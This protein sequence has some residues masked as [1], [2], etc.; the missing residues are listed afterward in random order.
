LQAR[1]NGQLVQSV[2]YEGIARD[3][4]YN[5]LLAGGWRTAA[6]LATLSADDM[7][8]TL[9]DVLGA[10][11]KARVSSLQEKTNQALTEHAMLYLWLL[12]TRI[13]TAPQLAAMSLEDQRNTVI[14][15]INKRTG[16]PIPELQARN[17]GQLV[18][19]LYVALLSP[20]GG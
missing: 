1:N 12:D 8:E 14:V 20:K 2:Y 17:N 13:R 3:Q 15:E 16:A 9:I 5:V 11:S 10:S 18:N 6:Q 7:R 4:L 19:I